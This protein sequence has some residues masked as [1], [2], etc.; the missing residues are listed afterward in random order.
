MK[1]LISIFLCSLLLSSCAVQ[2]AQSALPTIDTNSPLVTP[3]PVPVAQ[4]TQTAA[5]T[6]VPCGEQSGRTLTFLVDV[7]GLAQPLKAR[8]HLPPCYDLSGQTRYPVLYLLHGQGFTGDQWERLAAPQTLDRLVASG[9][10][11]PILLIFPEEADTSANPFESAFGP[12]L[13]DTLL[14]AVDQAFPTCARRDCR[15]IGG[16]SRGASWAVYLAFANPDTF[17]AAGAHSFPPFNG[18]EKKFRGL[19]A[20]L[21]PAQ[22]PQLYIDIGVS[23]P[24]R[25]AAADFEAQLNQAGIPHEWYLNQGQHDEEY[26]SQHVEEYLSWYAAQLALQPLSPNV[27]VILKEIHK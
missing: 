15:A 1:P 23:D 26:W 7:A 21:S 10:V 4:P 12:A 27:S 22:I 13:V 11:Q 20:N 9:E 25:S 8:I 24:F 3:T 16:L 6:S 14:P 5:A 2:V 18:L 19:L 17:A